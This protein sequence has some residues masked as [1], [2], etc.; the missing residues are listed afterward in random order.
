MLTQLEKESFWRTVEA[1]LVELFDVDPREAFQKTTEK[2]YQVAEHHKKHPSDF[3]YNI[4][5]YDVAL[6]LSE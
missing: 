2:R 4:E 1:T 3:F 6:Q 5:E